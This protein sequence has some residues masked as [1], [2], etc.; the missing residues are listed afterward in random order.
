M[1]CK[2]KDKSA[3]DRQEGGSHYK[4]YDI[5]PFLFFSKNKLP[6]DA[7]TVCKYVIRHQDKNGAAD[8]DKAIH[9]IQMMKEIHYG[10][11]PSAA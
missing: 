4:G 9:C 7:A 2:C 10:N 11:K 5:E 3:F 6:F 1:S 8:L